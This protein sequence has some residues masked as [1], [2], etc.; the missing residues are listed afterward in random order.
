M[1]EEKFKAYML[2]AREVGGEYRAGYETGLRAHHHGEQF[3]VTGGIDAWM[4]YGGERSEG[5]RQGYAGKPPK[6]FHGNIGNLN[7]RSELPADAQLQ[8]RLNSQV[9]ARY[10]KQAQRESLKLSEW[11]IKTLDAA[12][13]PPSR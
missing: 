4:Q 2:A 8:V 7:A 12:L 9:K 6:G 1:T 10:V 5:F 13:H 11:V 3:Q